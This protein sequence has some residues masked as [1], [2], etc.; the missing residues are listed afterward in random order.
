MPLAPDKDFG[1]TFILVLQ[2]AAFNDQYNENRQE[3]AC[4]GDDFYKLG[5][6]IHFSVDNHRSTALHSSGNSIFISFTLWT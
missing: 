4:R 1:D 6:R 2:S 3:V 5:K